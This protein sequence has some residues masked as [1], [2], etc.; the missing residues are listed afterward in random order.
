MIQLI[1]K[2]IIIYIFFYNAR[3]LFNNKINVRKPKISIFLP[4]YNRELYVKRCIESLQNQTFKDIEI[5]AVNDGSTD[6]T[7]KMLKK[8]SKKDKRIKIKNNDR[9]HGSLYS[10][11]MGISN[12][13]GEYLMN[14]DSD[15]LLVGKNDLTFLYKMTKKK[16]DIIIFLI[17]RTAF[18]KSDNKFFKYL[19]EN[20][21]KMEDFYITNKIV[22]KETF[23]KALNNFKDEVFDKHWNYH[24]DNIWNYLVRKYAKSIKIINKYIYSYNRNEDS[25]N[26]KKDFALEIKNRFYKLKKLKKMN[27]NFQIDSFLNILA[28]SFKSYKEIM[29]NEI[30]HLIFYV[31]IN[32]MNFFQKNIYIYKS[33][34]LFLNKLSVGKLIIFYYSSK[35]KNHLYSSNLAK[36][37]NIIKHYKYIISINCNDS[38]KIYEINNFIFSNDFLIFMNNAIFKHKLKKL[39][40]VHKK[41]KIIAFVSKKSVKNFST[42]SNLIIFFQENY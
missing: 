12:S 29:N 18:Y 23:T 30:K 1:K 31:L 10:R 27:Y 42:F 9:N 34:N 13:T 39:L 35:K 2:I 19:D 33:I 24:E 7:L 26:I 6:N 38:K 17:K 20:Q 14:L 21:L 16:Y 25:V 3:N 41:N 40:L 8:F 36:F 15:D 32:Y 28:R 37:R 5:I 11:A 22:K 4:I